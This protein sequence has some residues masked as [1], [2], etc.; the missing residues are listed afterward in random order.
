MKIAN[1]QIEKTYDIFPTSQ[2]ELWPLR[3]IDTYPISINDIQDKVVKVSFY[4]CPIA[5]RRD[6]FKQSKCIMPISVGQNLKVHE[7]EKFLA[8]MKLINNSFKSC[9]LLIDDSI[10]RHTMKI[11]SDLPAKALHAKAVMTGDDWL[12]DNKYIYE[13]LTIPYTI[14]R[15]DDWLTHPNFE[16]YYELVCNLYERDNQYQEAFHNTIEGFIARY[17]NK[18]EATLFNYNR[19]YK[20][21]VKYLKEECAVMCLWADEGYNFEVYPSGRNEAMKATY[22]RIVLSRHPNLLVSVSL[23]FKN[24]KKSILI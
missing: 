21:C 13:Q 22:E 15:W 18:V 17:K 7:G 1:Y 2:G 6:V 11:Q 9:A 5:N 23:H 4:R 20:C 24:L 3:R 12:N 19:A 14:I 8:T 16:G 10:Q